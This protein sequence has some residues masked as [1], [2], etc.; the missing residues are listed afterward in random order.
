MHIEDS[1][2]SRVVWQHG[3]DSFGL[4]TGRYSDR[5]WRVIGDIP[6]RICVLGPQ[7][8]PC[9]STNRL[10]GRQLLSASYTQALWTAAGTVAEDLCAVGVVKLPDLQYAKS[11]NLIFAG[12]QLE[13]DRT[14]SDHN[15]EK[16]T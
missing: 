5:V 15:I 7:K 8:P 2:A 9:K 12:K 10:Q 3:L 13:D 6:R 11:A 16:Y 1:R 14:L 4:M